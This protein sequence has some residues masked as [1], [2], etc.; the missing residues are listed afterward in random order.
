VLV[1]PAGWGKTVL[2]AAFAASASFPVAWLSLTVRERST[3]ALL[4]G[5]VRAVR[6]VC[7]DLRPSLSGVFRCRVGHD[8]AAM[9]LVEALT[10]YPGRLGLVLD[11]YQ[12]IDGSVDVAQTMGALLLSAPA[13]FTVVIASR[14][15]PALP[16]ARLLAAGRVC[17]FGAHDLQLPPEH[18]PD[19]VESCRID[20][21][22]L[23]IG[24]GSR[25]LAR[26]IAGRLAF[27]QRSLAAVTS[28]LG[29]TADT[30][31]SVTQE[32]PIVH[33]RL[34]DRVELLVSDKPPRDPRRYWRSRATRNLFCFLELHRGGLPADAVIARLWPDCDGTNGK[35]LLWKHTHQLRSVL[36]DD[37][38]ERGRRI[39]L[40]DGGT[41]RL[42]PA[43]PVTTDVGAFEAEAARGLDGGDASTT[44]AHL[45][46]A[47]QLYSGPY[48]PSVDEPWA[49]ARRTEL[50]RLQQRVLRRLVEVTSASDPAES[51]AHAE[52]LFRR[53]PFSDASCRLVLECLARLGEWERARAVYRAFAERLRR[54]R[55]ALPAREL[56]HLIGASGVTGAGC[57]PAAVLGLLA[58]LAVLT[59]HAFALLGA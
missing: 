39:V 46:S 8:A 50:V 23:G 38:A 45:R 55:G 9:R 41:L 57:I 21:E 15:L 5:I 49:R 37:D 58:H 43:V 16:W 12:S 29:A 28:A 54:E 17:G 6:A 34:L 11:D 51:L 25:S 56:V 48:L 59:G 19:L 24:R 1:A 20:A 18:L 36:S 32:L 47:A 40:T 53:T 30:P 52:H 2:A 13:N 10:A 7:P 33:A 44:L 27:A 26:D 3:P 35:R 22:A 42:N 4:A 31:T 14:T